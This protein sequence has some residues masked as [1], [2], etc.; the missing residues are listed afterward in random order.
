MKFI[1]CI[2]CGESLEIPENQEE[3]TCPICLIDFYVDLETET[4]KKEDD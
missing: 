2:G 1:T 4:D 3:I